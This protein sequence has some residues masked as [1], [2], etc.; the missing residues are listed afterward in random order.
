[1]GPFSYLPSGLPET[2]G[3]TILP[4]CIGDYCI[5]DKP[6][7]YRALT[8]NEFISE[9][10]GVHDTLLNYRQEEI[11]VNISYLQQLKSIGGI[12]K[13]T[14]SQHSLCI[15][16]QEMRYKKCGMMK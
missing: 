7:V 12:W 4:Y 14:F 16:K 5:G 6:N 9:I 11:H 3:P 8:Q 2:I 1:M 15:G 10:H 13:H